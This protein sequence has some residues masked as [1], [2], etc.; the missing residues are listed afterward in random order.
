MLRR[1]V[2]AALVLTL[3]VAASGSAQVVDEELFATDG[4]V[5]AAVV[6][7]NT[8][9]VGG[10]FRRVGT[11]VG[12]GVPIHSG[13]GDVSGA[14]PK[15]AGGGVFAVVPDGSGGWYIGGSF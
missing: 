5:N 6:S 1:T 8:L 2:H 9:Y 3:I 15:V 12:S 14:F 10:T 4:Q 7:G 13:T 11:A